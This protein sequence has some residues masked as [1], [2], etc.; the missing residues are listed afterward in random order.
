MLRLLRCL[1]CGRSGDISIGPCR[2]CHGA[3]ML[4]LMQLM[5]CR[6]CFLIILAIVGFFVV[7]MVVPC[8]SRH[9][10]FVSPV[11][12]LVLSV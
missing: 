1:R 7:E 6:I 11:V 2:L 9:A 5:L 3:P 4:L 10:L 12:R 8:G